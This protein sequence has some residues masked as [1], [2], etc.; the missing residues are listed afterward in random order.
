MSWGR[1]CGWASGSS[2]WAGFSAGALHFQHR[3]GHV[4]GPVGGAALAA[5]LIG[6]EIDVLEGLEGKIGRAVDG[7]G[8]GAV[9]VFLH[10][11][12]HHQ[13]IAGRQ[14]LGI[15]EAVGQRRVF[16]LQLVEQAEGVVAHLLLAAAAVGHQDVAAV[17]EA[18]HR[19]QARGDVVGEERDGAGG[20][21]G[22][23]QRVADAVAGD[24]VPQILL[25]LADRFAGQKLVAIEEREGALLARDLDGGGIG[26]PA[27]R[28]HP[29]LAQRHRIA[30]PVARPA[31][32]EGVGQPADAEPDA[33]LGPRLLFLLGQ[34]ESARCR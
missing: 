1:G 28:P 22:G 10:R 33:P 14:R 13:M 19:L 2:D 11:G 8:D 17:F 21:D 34:R 25:Q 18:E 31:H 30:G 4:V 27:Q 16:A 24:A 29:G 5:Q 20:R 3:A 9:D 26:R 12:L 15:D 23:E 7:L 32:D 6:L